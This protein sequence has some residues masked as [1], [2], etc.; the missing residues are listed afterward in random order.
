MNRLKASLL[1]ATL[2]FTAISGAATAQPYPPP[3]P[4]IYR[5]LPPPG[6]PAYRPLPPP[7]YYRHWHRGDR[8]AG[9]RY[10]VAHWRRYRLAPPPY[11]YVWVRDHGRFL[12][13]APSGYIAQIIIP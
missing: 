3:G 2:A 11:G 9:P 6:P 8:Y 4:P 7:P 10:V 13:L 5:P 1:A 12:L